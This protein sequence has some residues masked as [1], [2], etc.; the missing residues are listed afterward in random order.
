MGY[1]VAAIIAIWVMA[2][3]NGKSGFESKMGW[4]V[5]VVVGFLYFMIRL[6]TKRTSKPEEGY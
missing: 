1:L 6:Q 3:V 4:L 2:A 5:I